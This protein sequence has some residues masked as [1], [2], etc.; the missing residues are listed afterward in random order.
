MTNLT[1]LDKAHAA[2][3]ADE[4]DDAAR[5]KFYQRLADSELFL[6]EPHAGARPGMQ[7][8]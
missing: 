5:L 1:P 8:K 2:M 7:V 6:L 4:A 3:D